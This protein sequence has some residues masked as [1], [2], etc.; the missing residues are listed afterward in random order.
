MAIWGMLRHGKYGVI[1]HLSLAHLALFRSDVFVP[2]TD[3][4]F[5]RITRVQLLSTGRTLFGNGVFSCISHSS[6][7]EKNLPIMLLHVRCEGKTVV[8]M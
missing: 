1:P 2:K 3:S 7:S 5:L 6:I 8:W 4:P